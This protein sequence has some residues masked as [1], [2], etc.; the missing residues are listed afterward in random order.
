M[1]G[2]A[3][4]DDAATRFAEGAAG[5][6][7]VILRASGSLTS[8]PEYF[9][10]AL[11]PIP[12]P[13]SVVTVLTS[14]PM[15]ADDPAVLC[16]VDMAEAIWLAGGNQ[17]NYLG[18]WPSE[19]HSA[20]RQ[21]AFRGGAVG[22][23]SA[24]AVSLGEAAFDA[25]HGTVTS[26]EALADP[27]RPE[28]S[29]SYPTFAA[30]ELYGTLVDSHFTDREREGRLL[31]F[32]ARFLSEKGRS[33]VSGIG[34]DEGVALVIQGNGFRVYAPEGKWAWI[35]RVT[36]PAELSPGEPLGL[37]GILRARLGDGVEGPWPLQFGFFEG[38]ELQVV[39]GIVSLVQ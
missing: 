12:A 34:L 32:L 15:A 37:S 26:P 20:L 28:V 9:T 30:P 13:A 1:G 21:V 18:L 22:G 3:E 27:F 36:G 29:L 35:Y 10:L 31:A 5:G 33:E 16:W 8:Y 6:D 39:G 11:S 38:Q 7:I 14:D 23:T 19:L 17:W 2:G 24:G 4:H 25:Q